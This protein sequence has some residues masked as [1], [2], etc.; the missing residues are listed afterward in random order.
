M[1]VA[2]VAVM[3]ADTED[4]AVMGADMEDTADMVDTADM[5][6]GLGPITATG[7]AATGVQALS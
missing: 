1:A 3:G 4:T 5:E 6:A 2:M 7:I